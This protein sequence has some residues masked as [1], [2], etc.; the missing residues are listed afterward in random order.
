MLSEARRGRD[1]S[2]HSLK[3][4]DLVGPGLQEVEECIVA[5]QLPKFLKPDTRV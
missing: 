2:K 3:G 5:R 1:E 4:T